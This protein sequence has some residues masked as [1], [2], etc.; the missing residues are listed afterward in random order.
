MSIWDEANDDG[1][2]DKI[3]EEVM[4]AKKFIYIYNSSTTLSEVLEKTGLE[5]DAV[6]KRAEDLSKRGISMRIF[7]K[8]EDWKELAS[9]AQSVLRANEYKGPILKRIVDDDM[10][11]IG[12]Y[13]GL[14]L[15][16]EEVYGEIVEFDDEE[17]LVT[18]EEDG[19]GDLVTGSQDDMF[20]ED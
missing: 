16:D 17:G 18:I 8:E 3:S 10:I 2:V 7:P 14:V 1:K 11:N 6:K 12:A 9:F 5:E 4:S 15:D 13:I 19:T 20:L